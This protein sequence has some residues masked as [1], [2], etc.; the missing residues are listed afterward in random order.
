MSIKTNSISN[1]TTTN[2]AINQISNNKP[3]WY[4]LHTYS[5]YESIAK[6]GLTQLIQKYNLQSQI[7]DVKILTEK[8]VK[9]YANGK[10]KL[11]ERNLMPTY[12]FVK[13]IYSTQLGYLVTHV[14]GITGFVGPMG[15]ATPMTETEIRKMHLED[16]AEDANFAVGDCISV[17]NGPLTGFTG[18]ISKCN[19]STQIAE[20]DVIMF[21]REVKVELQYV[22]M[23]KANGA[24]YNPLF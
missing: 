10:Q 23:I 22:Q 7:F 13:M 14:R 20:V 21:G 8:T 24:E 17:V 19:P 18:K 15:H 5:N 9:N 1:N 3:Q 2:Y 4:I 6:I 16:Y 12:I 11:V